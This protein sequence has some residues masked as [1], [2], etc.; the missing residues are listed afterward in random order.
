MIALSCGGGRLEI[1]HL[2][3]VVTAFFFVVIV[4]AL[5]LL[6]LQYSVYELLRDAWVLQD[7]SKEDADVGCDAAIAPKLVIQVRHR[8]QLYHQ[9]EVA[10]DHRGECK[11]EQCEGPR[12]TECQDG[13]LAAIEAAEED[14][15]DLTYPHVLARGPSPDFSSTPC[16]SS[17]ILAASD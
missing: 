17:L 7:A 11:Q 12:G 15:M 1:L 9:G 13:A 10:D 3:A 4:F 6:L 16:R 14:A 8:A 2:L 5:T